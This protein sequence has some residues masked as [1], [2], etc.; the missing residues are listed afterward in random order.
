MNLRK[1]IISGVI[2]GIWLLIMTFIA[3]YTAVLI[4]PY[5]IFDLG[6]MRSVNDPI[7]SLFF[8]YPFVFSFASA[9]VFASVEGAIKGSVNRKGVIFGLLLFVLVTIPN[10]FVI[11]TSMTYPLGFFISNILAGLIGLPVLGVIFANVWEKIPYSRL[12]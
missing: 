10:Q 5:N 11:Y 9:F 4:A 8:A 2:G 1:V 7:T 3:N 6:G 12:Q